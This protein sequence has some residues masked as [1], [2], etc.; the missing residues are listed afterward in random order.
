MSRPSPHGSKIAPESRE[1]TVT[2]SQDAA[3]VPWREALGLVYAELAQEGDE[4]WETMD[5][6][7]LYRRCRR[8][9]FER[10]TV[11]TPTE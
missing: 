6:E 3:E 7:A 5:A 8:W 10:E 2:P 4:A 11:T 9:R 1:D